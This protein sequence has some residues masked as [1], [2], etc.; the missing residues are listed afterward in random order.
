[1][2]YYLQIDEQ[3]LFRIESLLSVG[4]VQSSSPAALIEFGC[5]EEGQG[6]DVCG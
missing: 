6:L 1:M 5:A 4:V 2:Y 3:G